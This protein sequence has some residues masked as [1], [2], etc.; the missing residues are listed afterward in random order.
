MLALHVPCLLYVCHVCPTAG[1]QR[2][3]D[4]SGDGEGEVRGR[5]LRDVVLRPDECPGV[6]RGTSLIKHNTPV[7][8][9]RNPMRRDLC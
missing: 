1:E 5:H 6:Y 7:G 4:E 3:L 8:P 9:C 2:D